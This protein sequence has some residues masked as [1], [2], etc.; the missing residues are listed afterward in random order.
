MER[1]MADPVDVPTRGASS[2]AEAVR[3]LGTMLA[4][5]TDLIVVIDQQGGILDANAAA[6]ALTGVEDLVDGE[7]SVLEF[8]HPDDR[9]IAADAFLQ[10]VASGAPIVPIEVRVR[11]AS[12]GWRTMQARVSDLTDDPAL[13]GFLVALHDITDRIQLIE[14][15]AL[16]TQRLQSIVESIDDVVVILDSSL[17]VTWVSPG[18]ERLIDAPAYTNVGENAFNDMHPDD[19]EVVVGVLLEAMATPEGRGRCE[20]RLQ[21]SKLGWRWIAAEVVNRLEDPAVEGLV[22]TLRDISDQRTTDEELRKINQQAR[23]SASHLREMDRLKDQFLATVSH[24]LRTPLTSVR[25]FSELLVRRADELDDA[26]REQLA[27][28]IH[29]NA[30]E[31]EDMI[32]QLLDFSALQAGRVEVE[33]EALEL[34]AAV[35]SMLD[36]LADHLVEHRVTLDLDGQVVLADRRALDHVLRNLLTNAARYSAAGTTI[37]ISARR[38]EH[39]VVLAVRDEGIGISEAEQV[40]IFRS[41]YQSAPGTPGRRGTGVGLNI[42]RR[43]AQLQ[44]GRL[45]LESTPGEGSTFFLALPAPV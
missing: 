8:V 10:G 33:I 19:V 16:A 35:A 14:A 7:A 6:L 45:W 9:A 28:R 2:E 25:G 23:A 37:A 43:Y 32:G 27:S 26:T 41:F 34:G 44:G 36:R 3:R 30:R 13:G 18:I 39:E 22:C 20:L 24:E 5:T 38:A 17:A 29:E 4:A 11:D 15:Q 42:A 40:L 31:M 1:T 21:H 12:G